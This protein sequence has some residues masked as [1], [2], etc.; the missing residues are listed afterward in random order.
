MRTVLQAELTDLESLQRGVGYEVDKAAVAK[1]ERN[2]LD[3]I[4]VAGMQDRVTAL[5]TA[6]DETSFFAPDGIGYSSAQ[7]EL[8]LSHST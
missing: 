8:R 5:N 7:V 2:L 6:R 1:A 3:A 4:E